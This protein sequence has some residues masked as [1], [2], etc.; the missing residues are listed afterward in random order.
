VIRLLIRTLIAL[1]ANAVGLIVA[2]AVLSGMHMS[3]GSFFLDII[4]FTVLTALLQPFVAAQFRRLA[5]FAALIATFVALVVT[6]LVSDG[7]TIDGLSTWIAA[8]V[9]VWLAALLAAFILPFLGLKRPAPT[10]R[11][12]HP[13]RSSAPGRMFLASPGI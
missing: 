4:I 12:S 10:A 3:I 11:E 2:A 8:T 1:V 9:I 6:D 5:I 7:M 13:R